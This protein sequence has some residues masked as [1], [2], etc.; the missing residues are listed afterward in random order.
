M[1]GILEFL[2][3]L[4][5]DVTMYQRKKQLVPEKGYYDEIA[6]ALCCCFNIAGIVPTLTTKDAE[7]VWTLQWSFLSCAMG[8]NLVYF[9]LFYTYRFSKLLMKNKKNLNW[10]RMTPLLIPVLWTVMPA[11]SCMVGVAVYSQGIAN[12]YTNAYWNLASVIYPICS[13]QSN[14]SSNAANVLATIKSKKGTN[15]QDIAAAEPSTKETT[16]QRQASSEVSDQ[17]ELTPSMMPTRL[18]ERVIEYRKSIKIDSDDV[19]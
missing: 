3:Y 2:S 16:K 14:I 18:S 5:A 7:T 17:E 4:C 9:D 12:F 19:K 11:I 10:K 8:V 6:L 1:Y 15:V 13:I